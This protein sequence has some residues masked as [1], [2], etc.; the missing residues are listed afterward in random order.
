MSE[1]V[2]TTINRVMPK[3][4][5]DFCVEAMLKCGMS[6]EDSRIAASVLV[7]TDTWGVHS[8]G[9]KSLRQYLKRM[10]AGGLNCNAVPE[11][12]KQ[13]S[14]W[15][16]VDGHNALAMVT[17]YR[18]MEIAIEKAKSGGIAYVGARNSCHFG[19]AGYYA[20]MA[21]EA[22]MIGIVMSNVDPNMTITGTRGRGIGS[23]PLAYA[24]PAGKEPSILFDI[25]LSTVAA[26]KVDAARFKSKTIPDDW[27]VDLEGAATTNPNLYPKEAA[28]APLGRHKGYGLALMVE[29]LSAVLSGA[30]IL[31]GVKSWV[32][33][34]PDKP[35]GQGH[36]FIAINIVDMMPIDMFKRRMDEMIF[37]V[38]ALPKAKDSG[39]VF[40]PG[41][42][43]WKKRK[44]TLE[45]GMQL[46]DEVLHNL[47]GLADDLGLKFEEFLN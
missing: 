4:L 5:E 1:N 26:G 2:K 23:N 6:E 47:R 14:S 3:E 38:K 39:G 11:I 40:L 46:P 45:K 35:T 20:N 13:G 16:M 10:R 27:L 44:E 34:D 8:H 18:A 9:T 19:A 32:L 30:E 43:E 25:A 33:E 31:S 37:E 7:T 36:A 41:E 22:D 12:V 21:A 29:V 42:M 28:L 15:A 17:G 24:V